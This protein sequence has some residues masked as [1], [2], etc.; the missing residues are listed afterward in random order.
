M[1][2]NL[3]DI[4]QEETCGY[5]IY[6]KRLADNENVI[7]KKRNNVFPFSARCRKFQFDILKKNVR[8]K[9]VPDFK[10]FSKENFEL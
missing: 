6:G 1:K 10:R 3:W 4:K 8:R 2:C 5:C 7:C 9:K